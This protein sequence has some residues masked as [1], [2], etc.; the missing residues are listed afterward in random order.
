MRTVLYLSAV[1]LLAVCATWAYRVNYATQDALN[2]AA[3]LRADIAEEREALGVLKAEWAYLNRPDRL[4]A[5][6]TANAEALGLVDLTPEQ[7][8]EV[9]EVAF[10]PPPPPEAE[11]AETGAAPP[12]GPAPAAAHRRAALATNGAIE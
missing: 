8:G 7:F 9:S 4:R 1:V 12:A 6:V 10:P 3:D 2:R 5:L 11:G